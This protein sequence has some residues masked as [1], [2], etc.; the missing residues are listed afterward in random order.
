VGWKNGGYCDHVYVK[1]RCKKTCGTCSTSSSGSTAAETATKEKATKASEKSSKA[2]EKSSKASE[3]T[4]KEKSSKASE[5][6]AKASE[7]ATKERDQKVKDASKERDQKAKEAAAEKTQKANQNKEECKDTSTSCGGWKRGGHC[8]HQYVKPRCQKTCGFCKASSPSPP[9]SGGNGGSGNGGSSGD[10]ASLSGAAAIWTKGTNEY[11]CMHGVGKVTWD[12]RLAEKAKQWADR[13]ASGERGNSGSPH[14][15]K[16]NTEKID[17]YS[18]GENMAFRPSNNAFAKAN[19]QWYDEVEECTNFP[20]CT[21]S[22]G[23]TS[24][25][26]HFTAMV[27]KSVQ[28]IGCAVSSSKGSFHGRSYYFYVCRYWPAPN[29]RGKFTSNVLK[30]VKNQDQCQA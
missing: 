16:L 14:D 30:K 29:M 4:T 24:G 23:F 8:N 1:P 11:R 26:G 6:S 17:G 19:F 7:K 9:S 25:T 28:K 10:G 5:K 15:P 27:W 3:T 20:G 12:N 21:A 2:S 22:G 13:S 18:M